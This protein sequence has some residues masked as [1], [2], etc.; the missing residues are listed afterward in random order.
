[1]SDR[2]WKFLEEVFLSNSISAAL[3]HSS[4]YESPSMANSETLGK[5]LRS[6]LCDVAKGYASTVIEAAHIQ[7]I[8]KLADRVTNRCA[9]LLKGGRLRFGV[10]H[11]ALN[12]YLK[13]L[14]C[15]GR[16]PEPPHCPFD[17]KVIAELHRLRK[18][19]ANLRDLSWTQMNEATYRE[20]VSAARERLKEESLS[21]W[22]LR[23][24]P[25]TGCSGT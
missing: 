10:A 11:K 2:G 21:E 25:A 23:N 20:L 16:I 15:A 5:V 8:A 22:E 17:G 12:L 1:M 13:F 7:N 9:P 14:W 6:E 3:G 4:T 18:L 19:P 24:W